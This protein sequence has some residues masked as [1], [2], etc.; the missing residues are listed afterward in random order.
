MAIG[1]AECWQVAQQPIFQARVRFSLNKAAVAALA[2]PMATPGHAERAVFAR[3][4]LSGQYVLEHVAM[5]VFTNDS[6]KG[7]GNINNPDT[8]GL[9]DAEIQSAITSLF[10]ALAGVE[11]G[12]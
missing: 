7:S 8:N 4:V 9:N 10:S 3:K 6:L 1:A 12:A 11:S 5:A 2:E